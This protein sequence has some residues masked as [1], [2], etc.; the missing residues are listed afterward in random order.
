MYMYMYET[1]VQS[2][3]IYTCCI[4]MS[5]CMYICIIMCMFVQAEDCHIKAT[6]GN[7]RVRGKTSSHAG[8]PSPWTWWLQ[9]RGEVTGKGCI[10]EVVC[11]IMF[12]LGSCV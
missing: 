8:S 4:M 1:F 2:N 11:I 7:T 10:Q 6:T 3:C 12:F 9:L 5:M